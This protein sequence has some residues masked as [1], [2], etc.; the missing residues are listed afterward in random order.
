MGQPVLTDRHGEGLRV[1][2]PRIEWRDLGAER[3]LDEE[4]QLEVAPAAG[5]GADSAVSTIRWEPQASRFSWVGGNSCCRA[6]CVE[7]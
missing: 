7:L 3:V 5:H 2:P 4:P 1:G 6:P